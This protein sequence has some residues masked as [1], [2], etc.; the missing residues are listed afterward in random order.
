[1]ERNLWINFFIF[2]VFF[3]CVY[4]WQPIYP[5]NGVVKCEKLT[6]ESC[7]G[8]RYNVTAMPNFMG[9][10]DQAKAERGVM[11]SINLHHTVM[12]KFFFFGSRQIFFTSLLF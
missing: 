4:S 11:T 8:L 7:L 3:N 10:T 2:G 1:M 5:G 9:H 6:V 12:N